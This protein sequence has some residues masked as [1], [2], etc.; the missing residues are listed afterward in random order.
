MN[1]EK[2]TSKNI[3]ADCKRCKKKEKTHRNWKKR[4]NK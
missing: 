2:K 3:K 1:K 4:D